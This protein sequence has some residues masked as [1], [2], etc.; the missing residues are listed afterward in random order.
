MTHALE[1]SDLSFKIEEIIAD[2]LKRAGNKGRN[3]ICEFCDLSN[4][5]STESLDLL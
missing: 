2:L 1:S 5:F 4:H 3:Y